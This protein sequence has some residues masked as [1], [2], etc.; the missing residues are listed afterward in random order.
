MSAVVSYSLRL[1]IGRDIEAVGEKRFANFAR[2]SLSV[3]TPLRVSHELGFDLFY[4]VY[5]EDDK[6]S[7]LR[8]AGPGE[9]RVM[10]VARS[11]VLPSV[12]TPDFWPSW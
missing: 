12:S 2:S 11:V 9:L 3:K 8:K 10:R 6:G 7:K 1:K 4:S 5:G